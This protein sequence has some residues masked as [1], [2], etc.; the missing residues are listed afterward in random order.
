MSHNAKDEI[1]FAIVPGVWYFVFCHK[2][3]R[4]CVLD[5]DDR[6][7]C[8]GDGFVDVWCTAIV[9]GHSGWCN[10]IYTISMHW[11]RGVS[12][13]WHPVCPTS[14]YFPFP[15]TNSSATGACCAWLVDCLNAPLFRLSLSFFFW[16]RSHVPPSSL[17]LLCVGFRE[18]K[19]ETRCLCLAVIGSHVLARGKP[20]TASW[21]NQ[22][23]CQALFKYVF[24]Q[25]Q[26]ITNPHTH[27]SPH[28]CS[29]WF[30]DT[31]LS[32][33]V[34]VFASFFCRHRMLGAWLK[35]FWD[36]V[37]LFSFVFW[38]SQLV[39]R[40]RVIHCSITSKTTCSAKAG[41]PI[42]IR[43]FYNTFTWGNLK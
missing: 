16:A 12:W 18:M 17:L 40:K 13:I 28:T 34:R 3:A 7:L 25:R 33:W 43:G 36:M 8:W 5:G 23:G 10:L 24:N 22:E 11:R 20:P 42:Q 15:I 39:S 6:G 30:V 1:F 21:L 4:L 41:N 2:D 31:S 26:S 27:I 37:D 29:R 9:T 14:H 19:F 35:S 38:F 32:V